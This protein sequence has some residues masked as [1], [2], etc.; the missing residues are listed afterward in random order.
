MKIMLSTNGA[1]TIAGKDETIK[2]NPKPTINPTVDWFIFSFINCK[3]DQT[4]KSDAV[5]SQEYC[6]A[7]PA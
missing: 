2:I 3:A 1:I 7:S 4:K 5:I 6:L